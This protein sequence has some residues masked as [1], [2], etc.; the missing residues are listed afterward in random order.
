MT[1]TA[2]CLHLSGSWTANLQKNEKIQM[3]GTNT[4]ADALEVGYFHPK[5]FPSQE[6][7]TGEVGYIVTGLRD[8]RK[9]E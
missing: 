6:L 5:F 9:H 2:V 8:V 7:K 1:S 4:P 3:L